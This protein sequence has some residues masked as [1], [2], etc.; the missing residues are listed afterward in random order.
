MQGVPNAPD[1]RH[2]CRFVRC[3]TSLD[4]VFG[5][6]IPATTAEHILFLAKLRRGKAKRVSKKIDESRQAMGTLKP[7]PPASSDASKNL[8]AQVGVYCSTSDEKRDE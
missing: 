3:H 4:V 8:G 5:G 7:V 1:P 2:I 6:S